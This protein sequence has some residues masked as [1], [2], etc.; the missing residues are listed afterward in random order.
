MGMLYDGREI[1]MRSMLLTHPYAHIQR[2]GKQEPERDA[3]ALLGDRRG[4][5][6]HREHYA[7]MRGGRQ[8]VDGEFMGSR[9]QMDDLDPG[10]R[11]FLTIA[12]QAGTF[13][14]PGR[15]CGR[16]HA[17]SC[18]VT[19]RASGSIFSFPLAFLGSRNT[20]VHPVPGLT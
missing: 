14:V 17:V 7:L 6:F 15:G 10:T 19:A 8:A 18:R 16:R 20:G 3:G 9:A 11:L 2:H 13:A 5:R 12:R 1:G 4:N